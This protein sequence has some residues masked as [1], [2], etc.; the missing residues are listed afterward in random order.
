MSM[1]PRRP[2]RR[3]SYPLHCPAHI[4]SHG[5]MASSSS[6]RNPDLEMPIDADLGAEQSH[7][8]G[9]IPRRRGARDPGVRSGISRASRARAGHS[10]SRAAALLIIAPLFGAL[11]VTAA[12]VVVNAV[13]EWWAIVPGMLISLIATACVLATAI[14][15]LADGD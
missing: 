9:H 6:E 2:C 7:R 5:P 10:G 15:M 3:I 8:S 11:A 12:V 4:C 14:R 13:N 1:G